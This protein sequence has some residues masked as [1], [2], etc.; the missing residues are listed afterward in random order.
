MGKNTGVS[1]EEKVYELIFEITKKDRF[2]VSFPNV[3]I[4]RKPR[5]YSK[6]RDAEI[7][8]DVS[9][10]KYLGN[11]DEN[12]NMRPSIIVII[13]CKDYA[14]SIPVDDVEEFHAKLQQIGADNTKGMMIT[15]K[16]CFQRSALTYAESKGIALARILPNDQIH[17]AVFSILGNYEET[18]SERKERIIRPL[19]KKD[20]IAYNNDF[21]SLAGDYNLEA[22]VLRLLGINYWEY[23]FSEIKI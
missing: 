7:E 6:D 4:R 21:F 13:E 20:Y 5:Y 23:R 11:P 8:F 17:F 22:L 15:Q 3:K 14:N 16:G 19:V 18:E 9:V 1:F 10:E 12:E 2:M